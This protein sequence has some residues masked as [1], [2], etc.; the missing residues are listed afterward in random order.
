MKASCGV[1]IGSLGSG[2]GVGVGVGQDS[3]AA[4]TQ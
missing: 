1:V 4:G 3:A 2:S